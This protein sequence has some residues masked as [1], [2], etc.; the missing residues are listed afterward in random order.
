MQTVEEAK[1]ELRANWETGIKCPCCGQ[2]VKLYKRKIH[3]SMVVCLIR[4]YKLREKEIN[5]GGR[6]DD[7]FHVSRFGADGTYGGDF[8]KLA[9]WGLIE[10]KPAA[11]GSKSRISGLWRVTGEGVAFVKDKIKIREFA[12]IFDGKRICLSGNMIG[13]R[14]CLKSYFDYQ[15][16][17]DEK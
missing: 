4:L 8:A 7:Y 12:E 9:Y 3:W 15:E 14:D 13:V 5:F 2:L 11:A 16:L 1:Q 17:M 10:A 6:N